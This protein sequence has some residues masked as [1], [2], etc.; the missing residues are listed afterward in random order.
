[1]IQNIYQPT[2]MTIDDV[3][4]EAPAVRTLRLTFD[5]AGARERFFDAYRVGQFGQYGLPGEG[6][7]TFCVASPPTWTDAI[8]CTFREAG[9]VTAALAMREVG[10][11]ITFRGPYGACFPIDQWT[12]KDLLFVAGGIGLPPVRS[13]ICNA[14]DRRDEFG[15]VSVCYGARTAPDLVYKRQLA[16]WRDRDDVD[17]TVTV[18]PGGETDEWTGEIGFVPAVLR[19]VTFD[20]ANAVAVVC[21]PP[22]MI[23]FTLPVLLEKGFTPETIYT[24]LENRMKCGLGKCGR[25]NVGGSYV[26]KDGP[27]YTYAQLQ[28]LPA[29]DM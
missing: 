11:T 1:M 26:C 16:E 22:V 23:K 24:T 28:Q 14:L 3:R 25:C 9:R 5:D 4:V 7:A 17:L 6:E 18:D 12:G 2:V 19:D 15:A 20:A 21:G 10:Q 8:E 13:V 27:V 29:G